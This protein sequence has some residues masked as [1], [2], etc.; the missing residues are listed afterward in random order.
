VRVAAWTSAL[1]VTLSGS[2]FR[3]QARNDP[4]LNKNKPRVVHTTRVS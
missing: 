2:P 4:D 3:K 1:A